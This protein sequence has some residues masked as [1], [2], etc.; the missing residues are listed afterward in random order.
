LLLAILTQSQLELADLKPQQ[1]A[2][3]MELT[4][5]LILSLQLVVEVVV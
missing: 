4:Q 2:A 1:Q 5:Y 3:L